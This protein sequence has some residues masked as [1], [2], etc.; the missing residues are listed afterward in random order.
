MKSHHLFLLVYLFGATLGESSAEGN[1]RCGTETCG[2]E[3]D[4]TSRFLHCVG[5]PP[6]DTGKDHMRRLK[7]ILEGTMDVYTFMKSSLTGV[8]LLGLEGALALNAEADPLQNEALV[9]MWLEVQIKPLLGSITKHFL[10]CLSTKNFSCSTYQTVVR[11]LSDYYSDMNPVRQK[12]IYTFFMYPFLSGDRVAGCVNPNETTEEWLIKNFGSFRA[13]ARMTDFSSLNMVF[14][15]LEVLHLLSPAQKAELL[16]RPEVA[17]LDNGTLT[18]VFN[19]LLPG[20][21]GHQRGPSPGNTSMVPSGYSYPQNSL[22]EIANGFMMALRPIGSFAHEFVSFTRQRNVSEIKSTTL[23]QFLLNWTL[24]E[25][26]DVY[27]HDPSVAPETPQFDVTN[28][29]DWYQQVVLPL[30]RRILPDEEALMHQ[31]I[32]LAFH[33]L[34]FLE[35]GEQDE[36][37]GIQDVC[38]ITLDK[39]PCGLTDAVEN[40]AHILHCAARSELTL[41]ETTIMRLI[42]ELAKRLS[43]LLQEFSTTNF[44]ELASD[45][46]EI[47]TDNESPALT[48]HHLEDPE[49]IKLWFRVK[50]LPLL[51]G[52]NPDLL[53]CLSTKNFSCPVYQTLVAE[54]GHSMIQMDADMMYSHNIYKYFIYPFLLSQNTSERRCIFP[55]NQSAEWVKLNFGFFSTFASVLDFYELNPYFSGL[56][57]LE[58]LSPK[59]LAEMLLLPLPTPPEKDLVI[60]TVFDFLLES[61]ENRKFTE[62]LHFLVQLAGE[63]E[64]PCSVYQPI[65]ER[66]YGAVTETSPLLEPVIWARI[67]DLMA[68]APDCVPANITCPDTRINSTYICQG[69][70]S[71][72]LQA[73]LDNSADVSCN[74][75]L[76]KYACAQLEDFT[77]EQLASLM[78]CNLPGHSSQSRVLWKLVLTKFSSVLDSSLDMLANV[79][80]GMIPSAEAILDVIG[81]IRL[82]ALT[83]EEL[84]NSSVIRLWF[85][86]RLSGFLP[87]ASVRVLLCL[88]SRNFSCASYQQILQVFVGGFEKTPVQQQRVILNNF[89]LRFLRHSYPDPGCLSSFNNSAQWLTDNLGP[90]SELVL[91]SELLHLNPLFQPLEVIQ[92]LTPKQRVEL[93]ALK[94]PVN[95]DMIIN[96]LFDYMSEAPEERGFT[97]FLSQLVMF[98]EM[99]NL[100][101]SSYKTL[102]TRLDGA[103]VTASSQIASS[104]TYTKFAL[105]K[106]LPDDCIIYRGECDVTFINETDLCTGVNSTKLQIHLDSGMTAERFCTFSVEEIACASLSGLTAQN[107]ASILSCDRPSN[108]SGSKAAWKLLLSKASIVLD[109]A[110]DLLTNTTL[111][112][113][114]PSASMILDSIRELRLDILNIPTLNDP[115]IIQLWFGRRLRPFLPAVS[116]NFLSCLAT[117]ELSCSSYQ[118]IVQIL[119]E[120]YPHMMHGRQMSVFTHFISVF[121]TR[122]NSADPG[123]LSSFNNSAQWLTNNLGPFSEFALVTELLHLNPLFQPLEVIQLL[124]PKQRVEL[125]ALKLPVNTDM[126]INMLFDY[127]SEAPEERGFT[128]FLSQL[129]MFT[130][131]GNLSCSSYKTLFTRLDGAM[132]TASSQIASSITYTKFALS[133]QLPDDCII[134]RGEC[135]V[136][137][138]NETDLCTGVNSTKLQIHL[139]SGMTAEHFCTF[140]VEEI[141]CASLSGLTAQ[142]L[143]TILSCD[144]ASNSSGSK[145]AWKLLLSK[146]SIVLDSALD[147]LT[148]TTL[149]PS[150]PSASMILD[151]IRELRLDILNIPTLNDPAIIQLWFG[152]RLRPFLPAVSN[153]FLSCL[154]TREQNCSSYQHIVQILSEIY[155]HMMHGRQMSVFTHF[156]SVF[157]T[158]NNSADPGCLSSF[159]NSAQWLTNNLGPFS[160][161]ALVT[162]LLHLNPLFQPLEVIQLLTPKQRVELLALKLPVNT[163]MLI[164]MLFDYMS[165]APEERG[166]TE[167]LSQ[168]VMFTEMGNLSCSSY[169]TLFTRLDGAMVTAS[170]QIASSITYTKFALSKQLPDDCIIYRGECDVT[171]INETDLCTGVN[172][173]KLQIHLDSGMTAEHFCTFSVEEIACA[174]LSGLTAQNLATI[175]SCDRASNSSGSKAAWKLLLSKASIVL[176]SALD[177]LTNTTLDPSSPSASMILDSIRELRLDILNIPTLNDPAIIQLWFGR[178]LRPFLPAVSNN[179]LSCLVTRELSCSSYQHIVQILSEIYPHMMH[180]RQMS[181]FTHFISVFLTRNNSADPGCLSSFNN[182]A[183]WLTNNLGPFSEFALVTELLHLNPLF[184]PLEVIQLLTPKQR[185]E[186]LALKLPVN[187]DMLINMLFDYMSEAP[188]ERGF[189]EFLSQLVMFTEMGNLSCSSYKTLF[190]R[191]DGAMVTASSQ[192]ASSITFTKIALSKQLPDDCIIYRGECNVTMINET[193]ICTGV[194]STKLQIH[195][196][197]GMTAEHFCTFSVEEIACASLSGLTAQNLATILSCDRPSNS[198]GSKAAWK[199]LLSKTLRILNNALDLLTNTML[200]PSNPSASMILDSIQ[201]LRLDVFNIPTLNDPAIIQLWF[202]R[203]LRPFLPAV[204]NDFLLCL[205]TKE[206]SCNTYQNI[207]RLLSEIR[208]RMMDGRQM[209]VFTHFIGVFFTRNN[210]ADPLCSSNTNNSGEWV[211]KNLGGFSVLFTIQELQQLYPNFMPV[212]ALAFLSVEQLVDL[213]TTPGQLTSADQVNMVMKYV[214][215]LMLASFFDGF[216]AVLTGNELIVSSTVRS[217]MLEVVFARANLSRSSVDDA[218]VSQW[219][220]HRLP[221]LL[222]NL[223]SSHVTP[224]FQ[225]LMGRNCSIE[226]QGVMLLNSTIHTLG[227][228]SK[229]EIYNHIVLALTGPP[230]LRC[231]GDNYNNSFYSFIEDSFMGFQFP[232]LT[233]FVSLMPRDRKTLLVNSIPPSHLGNFL[234]RPDVIDNQAQLCDLYR[235]YVKTPSFLETE[236]LPD[237]VRRVTL[238]CVWPVALSSSSRSEVNA[239]FDRR[240]QNYLVFLSKSLISPA[241]TQNTSCL[242]FQKL[243]LVLGKYNY[244]GAD[245]VRQDMFNTI[246]AYLQSAKTPRCYDP[247]N[248]DLNS[249][250]WFAEYIGPFMPFLTLEILQ[251]FGSNQAL[252]VFTVNP[253]NIALLNHS[254]LPKNLTDFYTELIYQQDSNFN[255]ILLPLLCR[256]IAPAMAFTQLTRE[257]SL[258]MLENITNVCV[259]LDSQI[260]AALTGNFGDNI[261]SNIISALGNQSTSMSTGQI[262]AIKAQDLENS[263][264][265][266]SNVNGWRVGQAKTIIVSLMTRLTINT[267]PSLLRLGSLVIG[268]PTRV[269]SRMD[270]SQVLLASQNP[271]FVGYML[272]APNVV[273][274]VFVN[275]LTISRNSELI[276]ANVPDQMATRIPRVLLQ[277]FT[278]NASVITTLN[279]KTWKGKQAEMFFGQIA[280]EESTTILGGANNLSSS[281]LQGF[282]CTSVRAIKKA[283]IKN[284]IKACRRRGSTKV[285]L[286]ESQLTCMY[287]HLRGES[288]I[289]SFELYPSDVLL[290]YNYS[291][292]PRSSCKTYFEQLSDADFSVFSSSLSYKRSALFDNARSCLNITS[293]NLTGDQVAILGNMCCYLNET[294]ILKS[295]E[296][297]LEKLK[298]CQDLSE[299]QADAA[300]TRLTV[301]Y[302]PISTWTDTTLRSLGSL[303]IYMSSALYGEIDKSQKRKFLKYFLKVP[304]GNG[305]SRAKRGSITEKIRQSI[306]SRARRAADTGCTVGNI[307]QVIISDATFPFDYDD[308]NQFN[309]CLSAATVR[310]NLEAITQKVDQQDYLKIVL[311]K[312]RQ[313]YGTIIPEDQVQVLGAASRVASLDEINSWNITQVDTLAALMDTTNGQWDPSL[314]RAIISKYLGV[315]GN[316]LGRAELNAIGGPNLCSLDV[317]VLGNISQEALRDADALD[318]SNCTT[319]KLKVLFNI[320]NQAFQGRSR[321]LIS[322]SLYQLLQ[323]YLG[324]A[325]SDFVWNLSNSDINMDLD[326]FINLDKTVVQGLAV[327]DV[328]NL[329]G[330]HL[331]DLKSFE[332]TAVVK[333]WISRQFQSQLETLGIGLVGGRVENTAT[334]PSVTNKPTNSVPTTTKPKPTAAGARIQGDFAGF[335]FLVFLALLISSQQVVI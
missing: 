27:T 297:L 157:L 163:D 217:A 83:S 278:T 184:K 55:A 102:F 88:T 222:I 94:L 54:L 228:E 140:S 232:N 200:D 243:V 181:V 116:N 67:D 13:M 34:Y 85:T 100:S 192:I 12:W 120:I 119:S 7:A 164:N 203:R 212:E 245:F 324:G 193:G 135:D 206:L 113:S 160:Q 176:D 17:G 130:E 145:A 75:T 159:N 47:F 205:A 295:D 149:D 147:L 78:R 219:L 190:T 107:L 21:S 268:V 257:E 293:T 302:G 286:V 325:P 305:V 208:P 175:L 97:E 99:G 90:F 316:T 189:T 6:T 33:E 87:S 252:Q 10:S 89:I 31:N 71:S 281:V 234:R 236:S 259:D 41:T 229:K 174:S 327:N 42:M 19:S 233:T 246:R 331:P 280:V 150:S 210:T 36:Y 64:V 311:A 248:P 162:E 84:M 255:P 230:P 167:F 239:W 44:A 110:L 28:V 50:L 218:V 335:T 56:E 309:S 127:M 274:E 172:S 45:V 330:T 22:S 272:S 303:P 194:N 32:T 279:R 250:A 213:S 294:Y 5:L 328:R 125:L 240:L 146:A 93:L 201:E 153:N 37:D 273:Q 122:N 48:Q 165:E 117:N 158:R 121:L 151:S 275:Q 253:L 326:T 123:C 199:L 16:M 142:N 186:L 334:T 182:S 265:I 103:M 26:A 254:V 95:T 161:F 131:M 179:F 183:Q 24:A 65:F 197:S 59:Q 269:F 168:L 49:F 209:S 195:L 191:L 114:S 143:A 98:T 329:L 8:P 333:D 92:L 256:C 38:S 144:R 25:L 177:L 74:F 4:A 138:I 166:F 225:I 332:N 251:T 266:L 14:S 320:A 223:T 128:E 82:S 139:D 62:V 180:G 263:L 3:P 262:K 137:F 105:S 129:V 70:D 126:L 276:L 271:S 313:A 196:D 178:R 290:Y 220:Q 299:S 284:L 285:K 68:I 283:Q 169:K 215:D 241:V 77:A 124:T 308:I 287:N 224:Y 61:P 52:V 20:G 211:Q 108:S 310:D 317:K 40:M 288:D 244:T 258:K 23:T 72:D 106:Q 60:N 43:S 170:S 226:R 53:S 79:S 51:P 80:V 298:S 152:R 187:T 118:H 29:E 267:S 109:S 101:C 306:K 76:E 91:V 314:A 318:V 2:L 277:S 35:Y 261:D 111:D 264:N 300:A 315:G 235:N 202:G 216:S 134:Y 292:V 9:Q 81:E 171:F 260:S 136:T 291:L 104:I 148:N 227:A 141:A 18:L 198:S 304:R 214:P 173:T 319:D 221:P 66:L 322:P 231:Y 296:S 188:E 115:A 46:E 132:V 86:E 57:A 39:A 249:T 321:A 307:T 30:L 242:A 96:M 270:A 238:P 1:T 58:V 185:V 301:T 312:L 112:P 154:A 63:I 323:S 204:S 247:N 155:P 73:Y 156:I 69:V 15:G 11:E 133:K 207:V 282:T 237:E 289:T